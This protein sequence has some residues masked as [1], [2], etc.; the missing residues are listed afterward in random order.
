VEP[1]FEE[2]M[3]KLENYDVIAIDIPLSGYETG[4][5][6]EPDTGIH[7]RHRRPP[8]KILQVH[9]YVRSNPGSAH[10]LYEVHVSI[11]GALRCTYPVS[12]SGCRKD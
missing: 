11:E 6:G 8:R 9:D 2:A 1:T 4:A 3:Q 7:D 5:S 12:A 10:F